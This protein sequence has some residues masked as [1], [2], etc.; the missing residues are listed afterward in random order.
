MFWSLIQAP[1]KT[2]F[3]GLI[4]IYCICPLGCIVLFNWTIHCGFC[5]FFFFRNTV[6]VFAKKKLLYQMV[7]KKMYRII[8]VSVRDWTLSC[9]IC[10]SRWLT[11][12]AK[13]WSQQESKCL[14][15][16]TVYPRPGRG[17]NSASEQTLVKERV[18]VKFLVC[19]TW[20]IG[21]P[22]TPRKKKTRDQSVHSKGWSFLFTGLWLHVY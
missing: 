18:L 10:T 14:T 13:Q 1:Q 15:I 16:T 8:A 21:F 22:N 20:F 12:Q 17:K 9:T 19:F 11:S 5:F 4:A 3:W 7:F 2:L 6:L